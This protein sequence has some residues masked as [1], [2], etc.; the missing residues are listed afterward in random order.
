MNQVCH[1]Q[2]GAAY[3][4]EA[5]EKQ[6]SGGTYNLDDAAEDKLCDMYELCFQVLT[7]ASAI[8]YICITVARK[9]RISVC[10]CF[11]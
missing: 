2:V 3:I 6:I 9:L 10:S 8:S 11:T 4:P 7:S 5:K 1:Q